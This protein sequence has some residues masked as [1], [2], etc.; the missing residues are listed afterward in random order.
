MRCVEFD[1]C[2]HK[3]GLALPALINV[4][5]G[6]YLVEPELEDFFLIFP[7]TLISS[8]AHQSQHRVMLVHDSLGSRTQ[9]LETGSG[10]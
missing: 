4:D 10:E 7:G 1:A 3:Q 9:F 2:H 8:M 6:P 5:C